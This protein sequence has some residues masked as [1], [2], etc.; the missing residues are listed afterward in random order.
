MCIVCGRIICLFS[1]SFWLVISEPNFRKFNNFNWILGVQERITDCIAQIASLK[2]CYNGSSF[3]RH[4]NSNGGKHDKM[5][6]KKELKLHNLSD[7]MVNV[8]PKRKLEKYD[9]LI[10][11]VALNY[12]PI[13]AYYRILRC[14]NIATSTM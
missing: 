11:L 9:C 1:I 13:I 12:S 4:N 6:D 3:K 7:Y 10:V 8:L 2:P 5:N 14:I